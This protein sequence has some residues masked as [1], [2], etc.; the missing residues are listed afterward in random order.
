MTDLGTEVRFFQDNPDKLAGLVRDI[1]RAKDAGQIQFTDT[2]LM[3]V[4]GDVN[5]GLGG[6]YRSAVLRHES[7][8]RAIDDQD[9]EQEAWARTL[10]RA[11]EDLLTC[12]G[13][14]RSQES[15]DHNLLPTA[16]MNFVLN[17]LLFSTAKIST[18]YFGPFTS[19]WTPIA[20]ALSNWAGATSGPLATELTD[21]Q[22]TGSARVALT[23]GTTAAAGVIASSVA[24]RVTMETGVSGLTVY[25]ATVNEVS[26]IAYNVADKILL[27][28]TAFSTAKA[29]LAATDKLDLEYQLTATST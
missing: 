15:V 8:Q 9:P 21:A 1:R 28:A 25:G 6:V 7:V 10:V 20:G 22:I 17:V 3:I 16:G 18:W 12:R 24:S 14:F 4:R 27:S 23:M 29:G 19:N 11:S 26:T 2:G 5:M 13:F